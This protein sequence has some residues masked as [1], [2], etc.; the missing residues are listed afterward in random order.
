M[1]SAS[2]R[3]VVSYVISKSLG[4]LLPS[5]YDRSVEQ[6]WGVG[7]S[8]RAPVF[9]LAIHR[10]GGDEG[11][12][13]KGDLSESIRLQFQFPGVAKRANPQCVAWLVD[14]R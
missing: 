4:Q 13:V 8:P 9:T 12:L 2:S 7:L 1:T 5:S 11:T 6:R 3:A 14:D 10:D